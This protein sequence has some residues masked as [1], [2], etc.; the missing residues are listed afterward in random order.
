MD[1]VMRIKALAK[2]FFNCFER[3]SLSQGLSL[4]FAVTPDLGR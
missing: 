2:N 4:R 1:A 3:D